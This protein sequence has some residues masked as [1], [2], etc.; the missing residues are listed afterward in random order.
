MREQTCVL[1]IRWVFFFF[2]LNANFFFCLDLEPRTPLNPMTMILFQ[3]LLLFEARGAV[4][5]STCKMHHFYWLITML[6][7]VDPI[8]CFGCCDNSLKI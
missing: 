2:F 3:I 7:V 1:A 5:V 8:Q 4:V 6:E